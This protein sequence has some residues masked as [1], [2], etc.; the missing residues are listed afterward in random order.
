[1]NTAA[2][3]DLRFSASQLEELMEEALSE[4]EIAASLGEVPVGAVI[5]R[6]LG[7][8]IEIIATAHNEVERRSDASA[9]AEMLAIQRASSAGGNWR[10]DDCVLAVTLEPCTMCAGAI[11][12]ARI[13]V[14]VFGADDP[15][16]G[17]FG[18]LYDLSDLAARSPAPRIISGILAEKCSAVLKDF[19]ETRRSRGAKEVLW[20]SRHRFD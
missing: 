2:N 15:V 1:M 10:L 3:L 16:M 14:V 18:S 9:H 17:A 19:F 12:L 20:E 8:G 5:A 13:P 11:K 6:R 7:S 4:A